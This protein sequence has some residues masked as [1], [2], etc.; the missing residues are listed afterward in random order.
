MNTGNETVCSL[1]VPQPPVRRFADAVRRL[2]HLMAWS[3]F[4]GNERIAQVL[5]RAGHRIS[6][7]SVGRILKEKLPKNPVPTLLEEET[8]QRCVTG[9]YPNHT[10][11]IDITDIPGFFRLV[12]FKLVVVLDVFSRMPLA[13]RV[14]PKEPAAVQVAALVEDVARGPGAK[15]L[16]SDQGPQFTAPFFRDM[17]IRL[18]ILTRFGAIGKSGSI[19][20]LER[21]WRSLK[22]ELKLREFL[23]L[24]PRDLDERVRLGLFYYAHHRPHQ[25][26]GGAPR[27]RKST[28]AENRPTLRRTRHR[29]AG[30][31]RVRGSSPSRSPTS[32]SIA[33]PVL[34]PRAA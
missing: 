10:V 31:G 4:G 13:W 12:T 3:G 15:H 29:E 23:P 5:A 18:G 30:R 11:L 9:K 33:A 2:V 24:L 21:L 28:T 8:K 34:V 1:V 32:I 19:A 25:G 17:M 16:V 22:G 20:L 26:F 7:R 14:F 27:L 6:K